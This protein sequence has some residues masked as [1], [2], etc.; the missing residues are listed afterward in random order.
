[1]SVTPE[2]PRGDKATGRA[3]MIGAA[4]ALALVGVVLIVAGIPAMGVILL[5]LAPVLVL[6]FS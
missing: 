4:A 1:M 2:P 3:V 5:V 6:F